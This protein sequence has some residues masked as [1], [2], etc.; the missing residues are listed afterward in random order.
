[1]SALRVSTT[2]MGLA[3]ALR[4]NAAPMESWVLA[5]V[6]ARVT[7]RASEEPPTLAMLASFALLEPTAVEERVTRLL[8]RVFSHANRT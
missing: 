7:D 3:T 8:V 2:A 5:A 1:M 6:R 4:A